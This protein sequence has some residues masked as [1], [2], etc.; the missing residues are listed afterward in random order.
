MDFASAVVVRGDGGDARLSH[1]NDLLTGFEMSDSI[2][3]NQWLKVTFDAPTIWLNGVWLYTDEKAMTSGTIKFYVD[4]VLC[5]DTAGVGVNAIGGVFNCGLKGREFK[6]ICED[7]CTPHFAIRELKIWKANVLNVFADDNFYLLPGNTIGSSKI[8]KLFLNGSYSTNDF[9]DTF[10]SARGTGY[11]P[12]V[13]MGLPKP[14]EVTMFV[15]TVLG[16]HP[17]GWKIKY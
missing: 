5:P 14:A 8:A 7:L 13:C 17:D 15:A 1:D 12:G 2:K 16:G 3:A 11:A 4:G 6:V 10:N 9:R